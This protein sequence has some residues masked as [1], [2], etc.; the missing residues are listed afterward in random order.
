[1]KKHQWLLALAA[2]GLLALAL[3]AHGKELAHGVKAQTLTGGSVAGVK[4]DSTGM[5]IGADG[6]GSSLNVQETD[7][8]RDYSTPKTLLEWASTLAPGRTVKSTAAVAV[9]EYTSLTV[10]VSWNTAAA[11]DSDSVAIAVK[12]IGKLSTDM[13]DGYDFLAA[14]TGDT[15]MSFVRVDSIAGQKIPAPTAIIIARNKPVGASGGTHYYLK[16]TD[17]IGPK[18]YYVN[19]AKIVPSDGHNGVAFVLSNPGGAPFKFSHI[20]VAASNLIGTVTLN[21]LT[22]RVWPKVN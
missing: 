12:F 8:D 14:A 9:G 10:L 17:A 18:L 19:P 4:S 15:C 3:P 20:G 2:V 7:K 6:S 13:N 11:A 22:I 16:P 5:V 1:M 21:N